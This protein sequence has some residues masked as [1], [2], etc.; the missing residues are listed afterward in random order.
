MTDIVLSTAG[1][2]ARQGF[3]ET[4]LEARGETAATAVA[5]RARAEIQSRFVVAQA[6]PRNA[7]DVRARILDHCKRIGFA[8]KARYRKPVGNSHVE[9]PSI[10]FVETALSEFGNCDCDIVVA[11]EDPEKILLRVSVCDLERN[12]THKGET[13]VHK[14]VE[15]STVR[16]G[17]EVIGQRANTSGRT[18]YI[19]RAT[20]ED[21]ANKQAAAASKMLRNLGLKVL[22]ADIVEDCMEQCTRTIRDEAV[23]DPAAERKRIAD[24]FHGLGILPAMLAD[25]LG[26]GL[27]HMEP[28]DIVDLRAV[29][30][31]I[32]DGEASWSELVA[33]KRGDRSR[34]DTVDDR[35]RGAVAS[36]KSKLTRRSVPGGVAPNP[37]D[38]PTPP[39]APDP[40]ASDEAAARPE[41]QA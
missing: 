13:L 32:R 4:T 18:V 36:V 35:P 28:G 1:T 15:R 3:G 25:Y 31:A 2:I 38:D 40:T 23:K 14:T 26:H 29:F 41:V 39:G 24:A 19:I 33:T 6:R 30:D 12:I 9:G 20:D 34:A 37:P 10:R 17:Q 8:G 7:L 11:Y 27:E 21:L 16:P 5:E 22:P